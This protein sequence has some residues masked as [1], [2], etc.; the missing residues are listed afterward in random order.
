MRP[1]IVDASAESAAAPSAKAPTA[2]LATAARPSKPRRVCS[3]SL[4]AEVEP[5]AAITPPPGFSANLAPPIR[6][7]L[8]NIRRLAELDLPD[9]PGG[10]SRRND[11]RRQV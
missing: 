9:H 3:P 10:R 5:F 4:T 7:V 2:P 11:S 6:A 1:V 8:A